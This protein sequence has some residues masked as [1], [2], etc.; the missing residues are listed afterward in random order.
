MLPNMKTTATRPT[1][2]LAG[3]DAHGCPNCEECGAPNHTTPGG[4]CADN[5]GVSRCRGCSKRASA[6]YRERVA[7]SQRAAGDRW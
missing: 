5:D 1:R 4:V 3:T 6:W 2:P 7:L